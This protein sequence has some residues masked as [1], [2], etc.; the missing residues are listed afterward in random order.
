MSQYLPPWTIGQ[1]RTVARG[2]SKMRITRDKMRKL[3]K[4]H[5]TG[6]SDHPF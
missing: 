2:A 3:E 1:N 4:L 5:K 6:Q